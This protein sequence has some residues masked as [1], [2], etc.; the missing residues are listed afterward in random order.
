MPLIKE[1]LSRVYRAKVF[2][3]IDII[4]AF[5]GL[6]VA[7]G[8]EWKTAF[9]TRWGLYEYLVLPFGLTGGPSSFQRYINDALREFLDEFATAYLD[10][11]L[12][13][14]KTMKEHRE[15]VKLVLS[16]RDHS[17]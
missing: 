5:N 16:N 14:S 12:I 9:A 2:S 8:E 3:K 1:T 7:E 17:Y 11:I 4:A 10:D 6:R 15:Y 13:Y